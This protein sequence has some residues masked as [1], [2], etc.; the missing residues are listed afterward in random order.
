MTTPEPGA[1]RLSAGRL[2]LLRATPAPLDGGPRGALSFAQE[3]LWL[4]HR[5]YDG[6][7]GYHVQFALRLRGPLDEPALTA[8]LNRTVARHSALHSTYRTGDDDTPV[9]VRDSDLTI[10]LPVA[11]GDEQGLLAEHARPRFDLETCPPLRALLVR[12]SDDHHVLSVVVHHIAFDGWSVGVVVRDL[13]E[14][15]AA[16][17][18]GRAAVLPEPVLQYDDFAARQRERHTEARLR[19]G[20]DH[21]TSLLRGAPATLALG[22][23]GPRPD[24]PSRRAVTRAVRIEGR[25]Y[26]G[27]A[28]LARQ[29][30]ATL[31][32]A[33]LAAYR[34]LLAHESGERDIVV[35][36]PVAHRDA[37]GA[38]DAVGCFINLLA[39]RGDLSGRPSFRDLLRR[40]RDDVRTALAHQ[41]VPF[42]RIVRELDLPRV[43][44]S[45]P[46]VQAL[47]TVDTTPSAAQAPPGAGGLVLEFVDTAPETAVY[48]VELELSAG[49][50]SLAGVLTLAADVFGPED[51]DRLAEL[52][53][54]VLE[55]AV[56]DPGRPAADLPPLLGG[57]SAGHE[58]G[59]P[60]GE[61]TAQAARTPQAVALI[62]RDRTTTYAELD[63]RSDRLARAL[64]GLG[65]GPGDRVAVCLGRTP[66]LPATLLAVLK[67]GAAYV[68]VDPSYPADRMRFVLADA[69]VA[70]VVT[71]ASGL[72]RLGDVQGARLLD[73]ESLADSPGTAP[74]CASVADLA[75]VIH[76]SGSTGRPKGVMVERRQVASFFAAM[77]ERV[78]PAEPGDT[79]LAVTSMS[80]D[81]S[82][83]ELLWT[84]ARG[85]AVVLYDAGGTRRQVEFSLYSFPADDDTGS[86]D[87]RLLLEAA[88][89]ADDHGLT[90]VW[91]PER[92]FHPFGGAYPNPS[93]AAAAV[94]AVTRRVGIRAG[95]VVA[96][97][98]HPVRIAEEWAMV[99]RLSGGRVGVSFASGWH[100]A[101][102]VLAPDHYR[103]RQE[104]THRALETVRRLWRGETVTLPGGTGRPTGVTVRPRPVS[105]ELP[106]WVTTSGSEETFRAAGAAGTHVLTHLL[107]QDVDGLADRIAAYRAAWRENSGASGDGHVT[108]LVHGLLGAGD[109]TAREQAREPLLRYLRT[110]QDLSRTARDLP[111]DD[112]RSG[113]DP[114]GD[115]G[116][117]ERAL[118]ASVERHLLHTGLF[119]TPESCLPFVRRLSEAGVDEIAVLID[120]GLPDET[121]LAGLPHLAELRRL[122]NTAAHGSAPDDES[123]AGL[124]TRHGVTHLQCTPSMARLLADDAASRTALGRL[125]L[126]AVGGEAL[127]PALAGRLRGTGP[128]RVLNMYGPTEA[129]IWAVTGEVLDADVSAGTVPLGTPLPNTSAYV[130]D[131][132]L[133]PVPVGRSGELYLGGEAVAR[134]YLDRPGLTA[135]RF[136]ADPFGDGARLYRTGDLARWRADG[137]LEF[138]GRADQQVKIRGFRIEPGEIEA[139][140]AEHPSVAACAVVARGPAGEQRLAAYCTRAAGAAPLDARELRAHLA[141]R[142]PEALLPTVVRE[143]EA[144]PLTPGG[145]T[146]RAALPDPF[147]GMTGDTGGPAPAPAR[148][149]GQGTAEDPPA[150]AS[151][152]QEADQRAD[153]GADPGADD[154]GAAQ[155]AAQVLTD[156][157]AEVLG[158]EA[159]GPLDDFFAHGGDSILV[160]RAVDRAGRRGLAITPRLLMRHRT[161]AALA[162]H[163]RRA[164]PSRT[165]GESVTGPVPLTPIQRWFTDQNAPDPSHYNHAMLLEAPRPLS[166][167][168]LARAARHLLAH[169]DALR[170][171]FTPDG[172][173]QRVVGVEEAGVV[174]VDRIALTGRGPA[175][176]A[177]VVEEAGTRLQAG[178]SLQEGPLMR[179]VHFDGLGAVPDRLL[180]IVHHLVVDGVSGRILPEDLWSAYQ[181]AERGEPV[182]L[183]AR[184]ASFQSW[185]RALTEHAASRAVAEEADHWLKLPWHETGPLPVDHE[186]A[187]DLEADERYVVVELHP[188]RTRRLL[189]E[190]TGTGRAHIDDVLLTALAGALAPWSG[191]RRVLVDLEGHGREGLFGLDVSRTVGWFTSL[192]PVLLP[193]TTGATPDDVARTGEVLRAVPN[194]GIG[195]GVLRHLSPD[196]GLRARL[197]ELPRAEVIFNYL[198]QFDGSLG[199]FRI[200]R[201]PVGPDRGPA[202][203]R[204]HRLMVS[205]SV[206]AGRLRLEW[207]YNHRVHRAETIRSVAGKF[208]S[209]L[210]EVVERAD[211]RV[212]H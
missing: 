161:P 26:D 193:A 47:L 204:S 160:I 181:Q 58:A 36:S 200:L 126:L 3:R 154:Q 9:Q 97:L 68:P 46:L 18:E 112:D 78:G 163:T 115:G 109:D 111:A 107:G 28:A 102:F 175:E 208:M 108:L 12:H 7:S 37:D 197:A 173:Q 43:P 144:L 96:P 17:R 32:M 35:G 33:L 189:R 140:L 137:R 132:A 155:E 88:R 91:L 180:L 130:L 114:S 148:R 167:D 134:G 45:A 89:F 65:V 150:S 79:W 6:E 27:L 169:H 81:I 100:P 10:P 133:R 206:E 87:Y 103:S 30:R 62:H 80:F 31:F 192:Y 22:T 212:E 34:L 119:G 86:E 124:I 185:S 176:D 209:L 164:E 152:G 105:A 38:E 84:L 157:F 159:F 187:E 128:G 188:A 8:A 90:A 122:A 42:Q 48:D 186:Q 149:T 116:D 174:P 39:L 72:T 40:A 71:D 162:P 99:D 142:L 69:S 179:L 182:V 52:L 64:A 61:F 4:E 75:Y 106:C 94:A 210:C 82:V 158:A 25:L 121:V 76:T 63:D 56:A 135:G 24:V 85:Y 57:R 67:A 190:A 53:T 120:F 55:H 110:S 60:E 205:G 50:G 153:R 127:P 211:A 66:D 143:I 104:E 198:G 184:T 146:D 172:W 183:P 199:P 19:P 95:S 136:V 178:L 16:E 191:H 74:R 41:E 201:D 138:L 2:H 129:T 125:R 207:A 70:V 202:G 73:V 170:T 11:R 165:A 21:W 131:G 49:P 196:P 59:L 113:D 139:V 29:E 93:V 13:M 1:R 51:A 44:G 101:D 171:R 83:L 194:R 195:H 203:R 20:L 92:H 54:A 14:L 118:R 156:V 5:L 15:Y 98:H 117:A 151:A 168:T 141:T 145:K 166:T 177:A 123:V 23:R 147:R 77:D